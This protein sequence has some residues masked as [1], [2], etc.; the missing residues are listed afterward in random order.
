MKGHIRE[1]SPGYARLIMGANTLRGTKR[2][3]PNGKED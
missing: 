3:L 2:E 1:R